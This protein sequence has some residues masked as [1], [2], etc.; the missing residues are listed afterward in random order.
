MTTA[1]F[2]EDKT[3]DEETTRA[4]VGTERGTSRIGNMDHRKSRLDETGSL[5]NLVLQ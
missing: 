3:T 2:E 1:V 4:S 5:Q